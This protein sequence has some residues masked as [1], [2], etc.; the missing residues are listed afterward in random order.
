MNRRSFVSL[1]AATPIGVWVASKT[2]A[3]KKSARC[4]SGSAGEHVLIGASS[5]VTITLP[6]AGGASSFTLSNPYTT[7]TVVKVLEGKEEWEIPPGSHSLFVPSGRGWNQVG[8]S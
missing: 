3:P 1:L 6:P 2:T 7:V 8:N 4:V 5:P